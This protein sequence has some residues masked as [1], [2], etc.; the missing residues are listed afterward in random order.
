[1]LLAAGVRSWRVGQRIR[2][3]RTHG[4]EPRLLQEGDPTT[5]AEA[6]AEYYVQRLYNRYCQ[7]FAQAFKREDFVK[8]FRVPAGSGP[9]DWS[10]LEAEVGAIRPITQPVAVVA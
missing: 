2:Y 1:V 4:G 8:I 9:F 6:D 7:Q 10:N 5:A 3:F